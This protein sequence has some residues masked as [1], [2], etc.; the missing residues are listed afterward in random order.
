MASAAV[1]LAGTAVAGAGVGTGFFAG[2]YRVL[3]ALADPGQR[4]G[5]V[6]AIW[7]VFSLAFSV[8][9][10]AAGVATTHFG[11]HQTAVV[12]SAV[13]AVLAAAAAGSFLFRRRSLPAGRPSGGTSRAERLTR[14]DEADD[15]VDHG[16]GGRSAH[17]EAERDVAVP[18]RCS[19]G[20]QRDL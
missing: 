14:K 1:F 19:S 11:L 3:A 8:P 9:V 13:L 7:I 5:L 12:Y 6:A 10:V 17:R 18:G 15:R 2:A 4:A 16:A 20:S